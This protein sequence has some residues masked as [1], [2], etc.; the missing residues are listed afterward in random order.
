MHTWLPAANVNAMSAY[1][2][3]YMDD[4]TCFW[5]RNRIAGR[6]D[7]AIAAISIPKIRVLM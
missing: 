3:A 7:R 2:L 6:T 4:E 5:V 1:P